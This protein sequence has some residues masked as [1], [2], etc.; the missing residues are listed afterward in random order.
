MLALF[1]L[2]TPEMLEIIAVPPSCFHLFLVAELR[3]L[4]GSVLISSQIA[5]TCG[6]SSKGGPDDKPFG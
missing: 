1:A 3:N 4:N 5:R 6:R 2:G